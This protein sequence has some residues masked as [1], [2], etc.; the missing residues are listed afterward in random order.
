MAP[1]GLPGA[2]PGVA[3]LHGSFVLGLGVFGLFVG[4]E[5]LITLLSGGR[6]TRQLFA[7]SSCPCSLRAVTLINPFT[8]HIYLEAFRH[9]NNPLLPLVWEWTPA[10]AGSRLQMAFVIYTLLLSIGLAWRRRL[11]DVFFVVV[12]LLLFVM[13]LSARRYIAVYAVATLPLA[14]G[15]SRTCPGGSRPSASRP[16]SSCSPGRGRGRGDPRADAH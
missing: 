9:L 13:S 4:H 7:L 14:P 1:V 11:E 16:L 8:Y 5:W 10:P 2:V 12:S 15:S 6:A 3:N